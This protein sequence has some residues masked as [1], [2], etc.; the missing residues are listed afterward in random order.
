MEPNRFAA[1][2]R[3]SGCSCLSFLA[4]TPKCGLITGIV[5][6]F[7]V[8]TARRR[9]AASLSPSF[10]A[11]NGA[12]A[13]AP[14]PIKPMSAT[15]RRRWRASSCCKR[16]GSSM[17][18]AVRVCLLR[19]EA[20]TSCVLMRRLSYSFRIRFKVLLRSPVLE[21]NRRVS[22]NALSPLSKKLRGR[23]PFLSKVLPR[24]LAAHKPRRAGRVK[25]I[26]SVPG[27]LP[28]VPLPWSSLP[29]CEGC[30]V[31]PSIASF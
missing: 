28:A 17:T 1:R 6:L 11:T 8:H 23:L 27:T 14:E 3:T 16:F 22:P 24:G 18:C 7:S 29:N 13:P 9:T 2:A 15:A 12:S 31:W 19:L 10:S 25:F 4:T 21:F 26:S 30:N 20:P 5:N